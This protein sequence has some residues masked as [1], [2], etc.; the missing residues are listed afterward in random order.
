MRLKQIGCFEGCCDM[1]NHM[2]TVT[3]DKEVHHFEIGEYPHHDGQRCR[4]RV[5]ENGEYVASF[6]PD[7][8]NYLHVCQNPSE[9]PEVLL[10][11]LADQIE[12]Q[13]PHGD[14]KYFEAPN[15]TEL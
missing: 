4:Y 7:A 5:F 13:I 1:D 9:L 8:H 12:A 11:L 3:Y 15:N 6:E 2:I 14:A 10:H